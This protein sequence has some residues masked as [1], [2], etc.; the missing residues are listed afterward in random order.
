MSEQRRKPR[1]TPR[2][3]IKRKPK[4]RKK[5]VYHALDL[6]KFICAILVVAI[7]ILPF[8]SNNSK[9]CEVLNFI[10]QQWLARIAVPF[11]FVSSGFLLFRKNR[12][13]SMKPVR[14]YIAR[15]L[16]IYLIW[17]LIYLPFHIKEI[18][19][20]KTGIGYGL[21]FYCRNLI[22]TGG[23]IHLWYLPA[24]ILATC[25]TAFLL[26]RHV[27]PDTIVKIAM[28]FYAL[29]L[30]EQS[31]FGLI[32]PLENLL[33][34]LWDLLKK[35]QLV[36]E[37]TRN[38]LF[39]GFLFVAM[40][41]SIAREGFHVPRGKALK[42]FLISWLLMLLE[43]IFVTQFKLARRYDMYIFLV[44]VTYFA[45]GLIVKIRITTGSRIFRRLRALSSLVF[46]NH[47]WIFWLLTTV[48]PKYGRDI[49]ASYQ[50]FVFT[51][52]ASII[53]SYLIIKLSEIPSLR[54]LRRI[55]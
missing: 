55:Y 53:F 42:A 20:N 38:G 30:L 2:P 52:I 14:R 39:E 21:L 54:W 36:I 27:K 17:C 24:L 44:P 8:G 13:F 49:I 19:M 40:G 35:V 18:F 10:V 16:R 12:K 26:T 33:P 11:F 4:P 1:H 5:R 50:A 28:V 34:S 51:T 25:L 47:L 23:H 9:T 48:M 22:F 45:F 37:T 7:H 41:A 6:A 43:A 15:L 29:G 46:Y 31:W 32:R 3:K